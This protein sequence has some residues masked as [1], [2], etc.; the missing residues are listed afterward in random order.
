MPQFEI[1]QQQLVD[2]HHYLYLLDHHALVDV[3]QDLVARVHAV[4]DVLVDHTLF[5]TQKS[6]SYDK[7]LPL[8]DFKKSKKAFLYFKNAFMTVDFLT[9]YIGLGFPEVNPKEKDINTLTQTVFYLYDLMR[10]QANRQ[11]YEFE[12][13]CI[14]QMARSNNRPYMSRFD[15]GEDAGQSYKVG[16]AIGYGHTYSKYNTL[17][18]FLSTVES[19]WNNTDLSNIQVFGK[20]IRVLLA[21]SCQKVRL[22]CEEWICGTQDSCQLTIPISQIF[23]DDKHCGY[24]YY[25]PFEISTSHYREELDLSVATSI[26]TVVPSVSSDKRSGEN[27]LIITDRVFSFS[28]L[29][30]I[31][32]GIFSRAGGVRFKPD[33]EVLNL[34]LL[35][36]MLDFGLYEQYVDLL[37]IPFLEHL[38]HMDTQELQVEVANLI[39]EFDR[40]NTTDSVTRA[41]VEELIFEMSYKFLVN[42]D[43]KVQSRQFKMVRMLNADPDYQSY[44]LLCKIYMSL[45]QIN[46]SVEVDY[47]KVQCDGSFHIIIPQNF[48]KRTSTYL[49]DVTRQYTFS[50]K[51]GIMVYDDLPVFDLRPQQPMIDL[52]KIRFDSLTDIQSYVKYVEI[53]N[54][55]HV[56]GS[57]ERYLVFIA[58]NALLVD[59]SGEEGEV[60]IRISKI[61]VEVRRD[62]RVL[63]WLRRLCSPNVVFALV[64]SLLYSS[65]RLSRSFRASNTPKA[66]MWFC[67]AP[68]T[69]ITWWTRAGSSTTTTTV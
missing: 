56:L 9:K 21:I 66:R 19:Y 12:K 28:Y 44:V 23:F 57:D 36:L 52:Y 61:D 11:S 48:S 64:R 39:Y 46:K 60:I 22:L 14:N 43:F 20:D 65:M 29:R 10:T 58:D 4:N 7:I 1:G 6:T 67:F 24:Y 32:E 45:C 53:S 59:A 34:L 16:I 17:M 18:H 37:N 26:G 30:T 62:T 69:F 13:E 51:D 49:E 3:D 31:L 38:Q 54:A 25:G 8:K 15:G 27:Q 68:A 5:S 63:V 47:Y 42:K 50:E 2:V 35:S 40:K 55:F 33:N 41:Q